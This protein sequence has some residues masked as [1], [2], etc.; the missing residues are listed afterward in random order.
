M[1]WGQ[2]WGSR[3]M[4]WGSSGLLRVLGGSFGI[5][6]TIW[7]PLR[8]FGVGLESPREFGPSFRVLEMLWR[9]SGVILEG[10]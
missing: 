9:S 5:L 6:G 4:L 1:I 2:F 8:G 3:E 10:A 7:G